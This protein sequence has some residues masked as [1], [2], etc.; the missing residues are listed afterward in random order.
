MVY[1]R[2]IY[3]ELLKWKERDNGKTALLVE[4]ARRV[5]KSTIVEEFAKN[6]YGSYLIINFSK[7]SVKIKN[8]FRNHLEDL[9]VFYQLLSAETGQKFIRRDTLIVF[10]EVQRFPQARE[11][12]KTL[13]EDG[14]Y[15][16]IETGSLV[17]IRENSKDI[18]IP[19]EEKPIQ[20]YPM[21]FEEFC[22]A[23]GE[24]PLIEYIKDC[25]VK[26]VPL[27][28][29]LH[30]K[31]MLLVKQ[32]MIVGGMPQSVTAYL[33]NGKDFEYA[34][35]QKRLIL[36]LYKNDIRKIGR[37]Y[38]TKVLQVFEGI[39]G[40][41]SKKEKRI[42]L[43]DM[44]GTPE[45]DSYADAFFWLKD[46]M[47]VN[48]CFKCNDP[49]VGL[50]LNEDNAYVKCYMGDTGLLLSHTFNPKEISEGELYKKILNDRLSINEGMFFE[51]LVAQMLTANGHELFF[52]THY[53]EE[54]H[55][56]DIEVDFILSNG[57]KTNYKIEPIEVKSSKNYATVSLDEFKKHFKKR[58]SMS[59]VIHPKNLRV[60][61]DK[62][63]IPIY[64]TFLL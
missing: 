19:S 18:V 47:I 28:D 58:T 57:S 51:N 9:D 12:I 46:S 39:P 62:I 53:N 13:V 63:Y 15:D 14:R 8:L 32:Y 6:S 38:K 30:R 17:S 21:D 48:E 26:K 7:T 61:N 35:E 22:V 36:T 40:F 60:D 41:L 2:K 20:M 37:K 10:D 42:V 55:R 3:E 1:K 16:F 43:K 34:D 44:E 31:A 54:K 64:M 50:S 52:Y 33:E 56:N 4:G 49:N 11:A 59:F 5:G 29:S 27:D 24:E 45:F 25:Y 23:C